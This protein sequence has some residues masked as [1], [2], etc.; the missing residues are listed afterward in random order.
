MEVI[1]DEETGE[2]M[3]YG[4]INFKNN[5]AA[6]EFSERNKGKQMPNSNQIYSLVIEKN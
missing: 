4:F 5:S 1:R 2:L 3:G 6:M